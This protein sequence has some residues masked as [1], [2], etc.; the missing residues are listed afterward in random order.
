[1]RLNLIFS[2]L[3]CLQLI[4]PLQAEVKEV[5]ITER[6]P[7]L[8]GYAWGNSGAYEY[9]K[10]EVLFV[11]DPRNPVNSRIVDLEYA[12]RD[13]DGMVHARADL[14]VLRP[15]DAAAGSGI[16]LVEVS[17]RGGKF[18]LNYF[19]R[20]AGARLIDP[21]NPA[22]FGDGLLMRQGLT[23][24]WLGWEFDVPDDPGILGIDIPVA[25]YPGGRKITGLVRSD[26]TLD[27]TMYTLSVGHRQQK[28]Y[29]VYDPDDP[30]NTLTWRNGRMAERTVVPREDWTFGILQD[31][32]LIPS[33]DHICSRKGFA[34]GRIY[35]LVYR[36]SDPPVVGMGLAAIRDIIA[37]AKYDPRAAFRVQYGIAAGV[38]QTGRFLRHFL[39]QGFNTDERGRM[40][41]D[42]MLIIT[43]GAGRGS[44]NH[45][46]AQPSRDA[47]R[48]SAFFYPT[49]LFPFTSRD[50]LDPE[51]GETDGLLS[52]LV[53][54]TH[55]PRIFYINTG[56]EYWGRA[57]SLIHTSVDGKTDVPPFNFER[58]YHIAGAQHFVGQIPAVPVNPG[59]PVPVYRGHPMEFKVNY[60]ALLVRMID[61]VSKGVDPPASI[62]PRLAAGTLV[63]PEAAGFPSIPGMQFPRVIHQACRVDYGD[64]WPMGIIDREPP[65]VGNPY[66]S[67]VATL[68]ELGN[69][70][71][72]IRNV[73]LTVPLASY[74]PWNLRTGMP[75]PQDELTDFL[76]TFVPLPWDETTRQKTGDPR[77]AVTSLYRNREDYSEK[78]TARCAELAK[79]GFLLEEDRDYV[80][81]H[82]LAIWDHLA[83][84]QAD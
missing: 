3:L 58:I 42:G 14:E 38:S 48:Y 21:E 82:A 77:P 64:R 5:R 39:Y 35:E 49:D 26:W 20:A 34:A 50:Q 46:F 16:A 63:M 30:A 33:D 17:N 12:P 55:T 13:E 4:N 27:E 59:S 71:A 15:V 79:Q 57:A 80:K 44:F 61:W 8:N 9:L 28:G 60:R 41:Y 6:T 74:F 29:P 19:N 84:M 45:R 43:A 1:M 40:A 83:G 25:S 11:I 47:H 10:G 73:E 68:D 7:V 53:F 62:I 23:L 78:V 24:I 2:C 67:L 37:Y 69:E 32:Q 51:T 18:S 52:H 76:G 22:H 72:G 75:G 70:L 56:Y 31:G 54:P 81:G 36:S 66:P 65:V